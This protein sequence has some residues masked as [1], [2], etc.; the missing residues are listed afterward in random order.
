M[1][2]KKNSQRKLINELK[3]QILIQA[4]RLGVRERYTPTVL[5]E[6][7]LDALR[8][9]LTEFYMEK[10]NLE[11]EM[12]VLGSNKKEILIKLERLNSYIRKA[13]GLR[14]KHLKNFEK[15]IEKGMGD[16][17]KAQKVASRL[18]P[19]RVSTAA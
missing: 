6:M 3:N 10:A 7:K 5:E 14:E 2:K 19:A 16:K 4:E 12:N 8:K 15:L 17:E 1:S 11:Y 13:Q 9:I 18:M